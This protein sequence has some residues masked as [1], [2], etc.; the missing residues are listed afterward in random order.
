MEVFVGVNEA[1]RFAF[2]TS[3]GEN[4]HTRSV[5]KRY[6]ARALASPLFERK[7]RNFSGLIPP[8]IRDDSTRKHWEVCPQAGAIVTHVAER[9]V[10]R[11]II[12]RARHAQTFV[13]LLEFLATA[14]LA[15]SSIMD[16]TASVRRH[17]CARIERTRTLTF[18]MRPAQPT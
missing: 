6:N 10:D 13:F 11:K 5:R 14:A 8:W 2:S 17:R 16:T 12:R 1:G 18:S 15:F 9:F 3:K 4:L 7:R